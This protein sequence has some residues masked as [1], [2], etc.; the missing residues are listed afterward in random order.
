M[1][2]AA[3]AFVFGLLERRLRVG[4]VRVQEPGSQFQCEPEDPRPFPG[5]TQVRVK[6]WRHWSDAL[7]KLNAD[8]GDLFGYSMDRFTDPPSHHEI[9]ED[10]A[11]AAAAKVVRIPTDAV[12]DKFEHTEPAPGRKMVLLEWRRV[13][14]GLRVDGDYLRIVMHPETHRISEFDRKWREIRLR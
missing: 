4:G 14:N 1:K 5:G 10:E 3:A 6:T 11:L 12:L 2:A 8:T 13:V 9:S 7:I